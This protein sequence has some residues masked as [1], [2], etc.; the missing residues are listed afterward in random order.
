[1][2]TTKSTQIKD[3]TKGHTL[4]AEDGKRYTILTRKPQ[5]AGSKNAAGED[6]FL[7]MVRPLAGGRGFDLILSQESLDR[8]AYKLTK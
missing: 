3:L 1:M 2:N 6:N 5:S 4:E 7:V 8:G